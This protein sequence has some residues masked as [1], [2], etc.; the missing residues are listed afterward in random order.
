MTDTPGAAPQGASP[1]EAPRKASR[2]R[3]ILMLFVGGFV[4]AFGGCA[5]FLGNLNMNGGS[6]DLSTVGAVLFIGGVLAFIIGALWGFA[7]WADRRFDKA[8]AET[9]KAK[10]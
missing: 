1:Q 6:N 10:E 2:T 5:L 7:R 4:L 8:A 3:T 9:A